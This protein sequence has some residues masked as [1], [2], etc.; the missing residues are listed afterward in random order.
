MISFAREAVSSRRS[1]PPWVSARAFATAMGD[2]QRLIFF[3]ALLVTAVSLRCEVCSGIGITCTGK[4]KICEA[5]QDTCV[6]TIYENSIDDKAFQAVTKGCESSEICRHPS[7]RMNMGEGRFL[8]MT[9]TCCHGGNCRHT[10][11]KMEPEDTQVNGKQ[12]PACYD[13][14]GICGKEKVDCT[15]S[16]E[17]CF[18]F[19]LGL[20]TNPSFYIPCT[21]RTAENITMKGCTTQVTC[22]TLI[23]GKHLMLRN[24]KATVRR[25]GCSSC[26]IQELQTW[27]LLLSTLCTVLLMEIFS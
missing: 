1:F 4:K 8:R 17:L 15:G 23:R 26:P 12:C 10:F 16:D 27:V 3:S 7:M 6:T 20:P 14:T 25:A 11:S 18:D 9:S 24:Q 2:L 22:D 19:L 21:D 13:T 5:S